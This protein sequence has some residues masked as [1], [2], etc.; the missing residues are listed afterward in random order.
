MKKILFVAL[1]ASMSS[2]TG[3]SQTIPDH[4]TQSICRCKQGGCFGG[5]AI[6]IRARCGQSGLSPDGS[7]I[8]CSAFV[9]NCKN[10]IQQ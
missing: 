4:P 10:G 5:N 3:Y 6:S 7:V 2:F 8:L 9:E 1:I